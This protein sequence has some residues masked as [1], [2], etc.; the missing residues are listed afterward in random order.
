MWYVIMNTDYTL[1]RGKSRPSSNLTLTDP[2]P[3]A[4]LIRIYEAVEECVGNGYKVVY[5]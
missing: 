3:V 4:N 5:Y 2:S 1:S